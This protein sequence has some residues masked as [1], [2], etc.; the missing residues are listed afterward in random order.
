MNKIMFSSEIKAVFLLIIAISANFI[1][2]TL[3][4]IKIENWSFTLSH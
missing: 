2:N 1:G 3:N 4:L